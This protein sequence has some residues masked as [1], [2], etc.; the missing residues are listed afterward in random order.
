MGSGGNVG[1]LYLGRAG[2]KSNPHEVEQFTEEPN[3]YR[4][5]KNIDEHSMIDKSSFLL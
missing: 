4:H 1:L 2:R 3:L 5:I